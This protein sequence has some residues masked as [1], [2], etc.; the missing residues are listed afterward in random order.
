VEGQ[1][2]ARACCA[3]EFIILTVAHQTQCK[4]NWHVRWDCNNRTLPDGIKLTPRVNRP[5]A[6][7]P[8]VPRGLIRREGDM[9]TIAKLV[10]PLSAA[11]ERPRDTPSRGAKAKRRLWV[12]VS[13]LSL[14]VN[15]N[16]T[17]S[18]RPAWA[19]ISEN[20]GAGGDPAGIDGGIN[21]NT[22]CGI[23][24]NAAGG[25]LP[26]QNAAFGFG[27]NA[28]GSG[29]S[30]IAIG[31]ANASGASGDNIAT[32]EL[33]TPA[34]TTAKISQPVSPPT[35]AALMAMLAGAAAP[36]SQPASA[37]APSGTTA[38]TRQSAAISTATA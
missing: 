11:T 34:A 38:L 20:F 31:N 21:T 26:S 32:A 36:T 6:R 24:A 5:R 13:V 17:L 18:P 3:I 35:P 22:A 16:A 37:L 15:F 33:P 10:A 8:K 7:D 27:A 23:S 30:N 25:V 14:A 4:Q 19:V 12:S 29:G 2:H 9:A 28:S 1:Q